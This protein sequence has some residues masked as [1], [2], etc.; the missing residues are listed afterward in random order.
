VDGQAEEIKL[1][2]TQGD[3]WIDAHGATGGNPGRYNHDD[4][5]EK[6]C[7]PRKRAPKMRSRPISGS[8]RTAEKARHERGH[9][10]PTLGF[11]EQLFAP[12]ARERVK[13]RFAVIF[14][15]AP[16]G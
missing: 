8:F 6:Q 15:S 14:G 10:L 1:L 3:Y 4:S 11:R 16:F 13:L 7:Q 2:V 5:K 9:A 12:G